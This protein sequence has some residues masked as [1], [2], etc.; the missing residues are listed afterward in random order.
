MKNNKWLVF[1]AIN[2]GIPR[3]SLFEESLSPPVPGR[4]WAFGPGEVGGFLLIP[5]AWIMFSQLPG[6]LAPGP[7]SIFLPEGFALFLKSLD[8]LT[9]N[10]GPLSG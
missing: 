3:V 2:S 8:Y 9:V 5:S 10:G 6:T 1:K 7:P 4:T